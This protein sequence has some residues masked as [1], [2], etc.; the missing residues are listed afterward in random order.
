MALVANGFMGAITLMD[1]GGNTSTLRYDLVETVY[2]DA[3]VDLQAI[4]A[5]L[6]AITQC[7]VKGYALTERYIEDALAIP[8]SG[9]QVENRATIVLNINGNPLKAATINIPGPG[10]NIF[11]G[12]SGPSADVVDVTDGDLIAYVDIWGVTGALATISDGEFV[13]DTQAMREGHRTH[14][15]SSKG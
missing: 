2:A 8:V 12:T 14:R 3:L 13:P 15:Q 5:L 1:N 10:S 4:L 11:Q 9:V 6:S 7:E